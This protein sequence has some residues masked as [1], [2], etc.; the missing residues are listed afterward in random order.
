[1]TETA[2]NSPQQPAASSPAAADLPYTALRAAPRLDLAP[3]IPLAAPLTIY[4]EPTNLCNLSCDFCPQSLPDYKERAGY[5]QHMPVAM[6]A[7]LMT[8]IR[9]LSIKSLKLYFFGEPLLHP[10]LGTLCSLAVAACPRVELTTNGIPLGLRKAQ[11]LL[12]AGVHYLRVSL[13]DEKA[14]LV[15]MN[16]ARLRYMRD[17]AGLQHPRICVKVFRTA[18]LPDAQSRYLGLADEVT[19]EALHTIGSD[20]VQLSR[21]T[22]GPQTAC[23]YPFYNLVVKSNGDVVPCCV[24]WERSLVVG[25]VAQQ[26]LAEI[27]RSEALARVHRLHLAGRRSELA[28]CAS[29]DTLWHS[30]D[31]VDAVGVME[32]N[33]RRKVAFPTG[34]SAGSS[35]SSPAVP[36]PGEPQQS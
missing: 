34:S 22:P 9:Q 11:E 24:A 1:M 3:A 35:A 19:C 30:P 29:C 28:A 33:Q 2:D 25:N 13:Y 21:A 17:A 36:G 23:A 10:D 5:S 20:F 7:R 15:Q 6:F 12:A 32:Y 14:D 8:E 31:S 4:V 16:V 27:W 18:D 26:T